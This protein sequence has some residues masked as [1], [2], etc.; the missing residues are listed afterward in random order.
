MGDTFTYFAGMTLAVV[1][2]L[3]HFSKTL[4]L[5]FLPQGLN[6]LLSFYQIVIGPCPRHRL[7]KFN[8]STGKLEAVT[9]HHTLVNL[10]LYICG[11]LRED[12]LCKVLLLFQVISNVF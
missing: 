2:T 6:F 4:A 12:D 3:G 10:T 11:P 1:G 7:P 5:L 8:K 9:S